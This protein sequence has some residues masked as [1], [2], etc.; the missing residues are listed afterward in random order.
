MVRAIE[1]MLQTDLS[2]SEIA[3][4][5]GYGSLPAFSNTFYQL[6]NFRTSEFKKNF[7]TAQPTLLLMEK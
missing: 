2:M 5:V 3:C 4:T 7:L 6:T 1:L